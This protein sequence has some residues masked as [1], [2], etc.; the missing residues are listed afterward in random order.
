[1]REYLNIVPISKN[2]CLQDIHWDIG[3][4]S[5]YSNCFI[6]AGM[7]MKKVKTLSPNIMQEISSGDFNNLNMLLNKNI[8]NFGSLKTT[9]DLVKDATGYG[10]IEPMVFID[11]I[12]EKYLS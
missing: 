9:K 1:M 7:A 12:K 6:I 10:N 5:A 4:F 3:N 2:S 11:Y 8:R